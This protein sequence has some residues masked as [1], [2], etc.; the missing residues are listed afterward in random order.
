MLQEIFHDFVTEAQTNQKQLFVLV[1][2]EAHW[3]I[4]PN[5]S[6]DFFVNSTKL[7]ELPNVIVLL[8]SATPANILTSDSRIPHQF[9][10][11]A[12]TPPML[13]ST[14]TGMLCPSF[15]SSCQRGIRIHAPQTA[16]G[17]ILR[18]LK[19]TRP[20]PSICILAQHIWRKCS[21]A[22]VPQMTA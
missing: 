2:D 3:G 13:A 6:H 18:D 17:P 11:S 14:P 15:Q 16:E 20:F 12:A 7:A 8:V 10:P 21:H 4:T 9:L 1:A 19:V 5:S 22:A